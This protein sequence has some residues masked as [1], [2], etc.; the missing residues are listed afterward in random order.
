MDLTNTA[1]RVVQIHPTLRCNLRCLHC[2]SS[3]GPQE[4]TE[5]NPEILKAALTDAYS[6]GYGTA[7]FSGGEPTLYKA[8]PAL[9][10]H[11]HD[12]GML[13]G[14]VSNGMLL[15][16]KRLK[17]IQG[18]TD[19]L[20][21]SL[22]GI[23]ASHNRNRASERAF[24]AM[25]ARLEGVRQSNILFGFL[26]T[27][28]QTNLD[29]LDWVAHFALEQGAKLLQVHPLEHTGRAV[30]TMLEEV[31][32]ETEMAYAF[33]EAF[34]LQAEMGNQLYIHL[35][36]ATRQALRNDPARVF[37]DGIRTEQNAP[38]L[39]DLI[40]PLII[41][42][43]GTVMPIEYGLDSRFKL[44]NINTARL[45]DLIPPWRRNIYPDFVRLCKSAFAEIISPNTPAFLNWYEILTR[46]VRV[47]Q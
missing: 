28:T 25:K 4:S 37:A 6:Q 42:A 20:A 40:S 46:T 8:L 43:D 45:N 15:D 9:L 16:E 26:F 36:I 29:E 30:E 23:P 7:S 10:G 33:T 13:T 32:D 41:E 3:S 1:N 11:A 2:Y 14:I 35:D 18:V 34:R 24:D 27:L 39:A 38:L 47:A 21:I 31:P 5:L 19:I 22:D 44:G 17:S 12:L